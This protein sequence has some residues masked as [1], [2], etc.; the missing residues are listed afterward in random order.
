[1]ELQSS[2][3]RIKGV[4]VT[5]GAALAALGL[6]GLAIAEPHGAGADSCTARPVVEQFIAA[7][8]AG[9]V[10]LAEQLFA[11]KGEGWNWYSVADRAGQRLGVE[12]KSRSSLAAYFASRVRQRE[13]LR[14]VSL[15]EG[16]N[17]NFGL[18]LIRRADDLRNGRPA[19]RVGKGWVNC[20]VRKISVWSLGGAP[21]PP[22]F[23]SC[24]RGTVPLT[25]ADLLPASRAV[26]RFI[27]AVYSEMSPGL[28]VAG[29][30]VTRATPAPGE[31]KGY[32][33]RVRCGLGVQQRTAIV[34][35]R[36]PRVD[37]R[38][39]LASVAFYASRTL[40]GWLVWRL[41]V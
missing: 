5:V 13:S 4:R 22:T 23:G 12:S 36:F 39:R 25:K 9:D 38:E 33:V 17:G 35:V 34:E 26:L 21:P 6:A 41:I 16:G 29:A 40:R 7:L 30:Y 15:R 3:R 20:V 10:G 31:V 8:N 32:A 24:P 19:K 2:V 28:D 27:A 14:L 11:E 37:S 18:V 1:M